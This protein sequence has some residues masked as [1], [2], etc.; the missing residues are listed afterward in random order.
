MLAKASNRL[1]INIL[2]P[3]TNER[4]PRELP[5][6]MKPRRIEIQTGK[7]LGKGDKVRTIEHSKIA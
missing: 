7:A 1:D 2:E 6:A 3:R 5:E 4:C